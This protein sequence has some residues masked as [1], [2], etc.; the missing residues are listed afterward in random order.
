M[1]HKQVITYNPFPKGLL[2]CKSV[3]FPAKKMMDFTASRAF[4]AKNS[5]HKKQFLIKINSL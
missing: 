2:V 4:V 1:Y 5:M 3:Q